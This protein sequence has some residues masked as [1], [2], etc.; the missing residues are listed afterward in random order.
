MRPLR[1]LGPTYLQIKRT[2]WPQKRADCRGHKQHVLSLQRQPL[3][4]WHNSFL[5]LLGPFF[6]GRQN[7]GYIYFLIANTEFAVLSGWDY[8]F[9]NPRSFNPLTSKSEVRAT[10]FWVGS[11][12]TRSFFRELGPSF[13][14]AE[15]GS[16]LSCRDC[17][18]FFTFTGIFLAPRQHNGNDPVV[19]WWRCRSAVSVE[20]LIFLMPVFLFLFFCTS[21][22]FF[23]RFFFLRVFFPSLFSFLYLFVFFL[24][25]RWV[26]RVITGWT[27]ATC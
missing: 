22:D 26:C 24:S 9:P 23:V 5:V 6:S 13:H 20:D 27:V 2:T 3:Y 11:P 25:G 21:C 17:A 10:I 7:F 12:Q 8:Q 16:N 19:T 18:A 4:H 15:L 14:P 1:V